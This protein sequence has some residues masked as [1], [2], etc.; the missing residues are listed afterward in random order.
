MLLQLQHQA[1]L[2]VCSWPIIPFPVWDRVRCFLCGLASSE[3]CKCVTRL[4]D[5][6]IQVRLLSQK[7]QKRLSIDR[8]WL[9]LPINYSVRRFHPMWCCG[10]LVHGLTGEQGRATEFVW[11]FVRQ[12]F[13]L[14]S[15]MDYLWTGPQQKNIDIKLMWQNNQVGRKQ[16][17]WQNSYRTTILAAFGKQFR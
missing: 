11:I 16:R 15:N 10:A 6:V 14:P 13:R 7:M 8:C 4:A 1:F 12:L 2:H 3:S 5:V 17:R 9:F